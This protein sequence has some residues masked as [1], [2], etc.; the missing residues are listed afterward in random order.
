M[1][2]RMLLALLAMVAFPALAADA[3]HQYESPFYRNQFAVS[4]VTQGRA[5]TANKT[6]D[7]RPAATNEPK[8]SAQKCTCQRPTT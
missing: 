6:D 8:A 1:R 5:E 2:N 4:H 3:S 7:A